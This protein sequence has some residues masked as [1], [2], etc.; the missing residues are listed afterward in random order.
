MKRQAFWEAEYSYINQGDWQKL[1]S[2]KWFSKGEDHLLVETTE[3]PRDVGEPHPKHYSLKW[4]KESA[5]S[6]EPK[7]MWQ[8]VPTTPEWKG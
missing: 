4:H 2:H 1:K 6:R 8:A 7:T 5:K 3:K